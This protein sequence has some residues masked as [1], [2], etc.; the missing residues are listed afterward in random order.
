MSKW[1]TGM[2]DRESIILNNTED[3]TGS[4]SV[5]YTAPWHDL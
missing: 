1:E 2:K 3:I 4:L 5:G